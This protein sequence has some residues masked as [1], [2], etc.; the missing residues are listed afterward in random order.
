ML[1]KFSRDLTVSSNILAVLSESTKKVGKGKD[2]KVYQKFKVICG[3]NGKL[4]TR[5][6]KKGS[7]CSVGDSL[8]VKEFVELFRKQ[9]PRFQEIFELEYKELYKQFKKLENGK[10][11]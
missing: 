2:V 6:Q 4:G 9:S 1:V 8:S 3:S 7:P 5:Y 11:N 10:D